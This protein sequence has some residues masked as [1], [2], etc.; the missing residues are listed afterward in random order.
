MGKT[1]RPT[2]SHELMRDIANASPGDTIL[3]KPGLY[4]IDR[5]FKFDNLNIQ[6][7]TDDASQVKLKPLEGRLFRDQGGSVFKNFSAIGGGSIIEAEGNNTTIE[8]FISW[9]SNLP[10]KLAGD[11]HIF[12]GGLI[13]QAGREGIEVNGGFYLLPELSD[14]PL[15]LK[16]EL[17]LINGMNPSQNWN[18]EQIKKFEKLFYH[19]NMKNVIRNVTGVRCGFR[20]GM[21][22]GG[23]IKCVP[24]AGGTVIED[25]VGIENLNDYWFDFPSSELITIRSNLSVRAYANPIFVEGYIRTNG[26]A[27]I[28]NNLV[29]DPV[30]RAMF[31]SAFT[32]AFSWGNTFYF[33][34]HG[35]VVHGLTGSREAMSVHCT[36]PEGKDSD[37]LI[38][39]NPLFYLAHQVAAYEAGYDFEKDEIYIMNEGQ[40]SYKVETPNN[41]IDEPLTEI[42]AQI[43]EGAKPTNEELLQYI[44][45]RYQLPE[46]VGVLKQ[47]MV[48][49]TDNSGG[50]NTGGG[51]DGG[52]DGDG[53]E[54]TDPRPGNDLP[55][56]W[57]MQDFPNFR[58]DGTYDSDTDNIVFFAPLFLCQPGRYNIK[59]ITVGTYPNP[60]YSSGYKYK[61]VLE[62]FDKEVRPKVEAE[63][64]TIDFPV[65]IADSHRKKFDGQ[66]ESNEINKIIQ[67]LREVDHLNVA[68]DGALTEAAHL[69]NE[70]ISIDESLLSKLSIYTHYTFSS[71]HHNHKLDKL[72]YQYLKKLANDDRINFIEFDKSGAVKIDDKTFPKMSDSV[73]NSQ[74]GSLFKFKWN[75]NKPDFSGFIIMLGIGGFENLGFDDNFRGNLKKDGSSNLELVSNTFGK[76]KGDLYKI[77]ET[78]AE[79]AVKGELKTDTGGNNG[80]GDDGNNSNELQELKDKLQAYEKATGD[81]VAA[82]SAA[83]VAFTEEMNK[84]K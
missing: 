13:F 62:A 54:N 68:T 2:D 50:N 3:I 37:K 77:I 60:E 9:M 4:V 20:G 82:L 63:W 12:D 29:I 27:E 57:I 19:R 32:D 65:V 44:D 84:L 35:K 14:R 55:N 59:G 21:T 23:F 61:S 1:Y 75:H 42:G 66:I 11:N 46:V 25:C 81:F 45:I 16:Q 30:D 24:N 73:L 39:T 71:T 52:N 72:A 33:N 49:I 31:V 58:S 26:L 53:N 74:I 41:N 79:K 43:W 7:A 34:R 48:I 18:T 69:V 64:G 70:I 6:G 8:N 17:G 47:E 40:I 76:Q 83:I 22:Y 36:T 67:V 78:Q 5:I 15:R 28:Y 80:G 56:V 38:S 51:N 10:V